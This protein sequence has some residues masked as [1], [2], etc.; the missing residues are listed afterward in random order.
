[1]KKIMFGLFI[2]IFI[3]LT[4]CDKPEITVPIEQPKDYS[5]S[6]E[7]LESFFTLESSVVETNR[8]YFIHVSFTPKFDY[9]D[10]I[11]TVTFGIYYEFT[12]Q[13]VLLNHYIE[14]T[15]TIHEDAV[16]SS[17][18]IQYFN[19]LSIVDVIVIEASGTFQSMETIALIQK[20]YIEPFD[21][22]HV[23]SKQIET[24]M[25]LKSQIDAINLAGQHMITKYSTITTESTQDGEHESFT[26]DY[27]EYLVRDPLYYHLKFNDHEFIH[28]I[29]DEQNVVYTWLGETFE[30]IKLLD[31]YVCKDDTTYPCEIP[32][33]SVISDTINLK[34]SKMTFEKDGHDF[35][36]RGLIKD[37]L[38]PYE[39]I[40]MVQSF[41]MMGLTQ[42]I[43]DQATF[44]LTLRFDQDLFQKTVVNIDI[45]SMDLHIKSTTEETYTF[46][47]ITPIDPF[48]HPSYQVLLPTSINAV[49]QDTDFLTEV[50]GGG[51]GQI[52]YYRSFLEKGVYRINAFD[53]MISFAL[54]DEAGHEI[55]NTIPNVYFSMPL[56]EVPHDGVYYVAIYRNDSSLPSYRF[57]FTKTDMMDFIYPEIDLN[58]PGEKSFIVENQDDLVRF[59]YTTTQK[60]VLTFTIISDQTT[61]FYSPYVND[62]INVTQAKTISVGVL[63]GTHTFYIGGMGYA[64]GTLS[65]EII[66]LPNIYSIS[67]TTL[68]ISENF[69]PSPIFYGGNLG[70]AYFILHVTETTTY[71]FEMTFTYATLYQK[72]G[73]NYM[74]LQTIYPN[75][76]VTL[77]PGTYYLSANSGFLSQG[78]IRYHKP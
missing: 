46:E 75:G 14:D 24:Y 16:S 63:P 60:E 9:I 64:A 31:L 68:E 47:S 53:S 54:F 17:Y 27:Y 69:F 65:V 51:R 44:E 43:V 77:E 2:L 21:R 58:I 74:T 30:N 12:Y 4:A 59:V 50:I 3:F 29:K 1:M 10:L 19:N 8:T 42:Y 26:T 66:V 11:G 62:Q 37:L 32:K 71:Q 52:H 33:D 73:S 20:T 67:Q 36:V 38:N 78:N 48:N 56:L 34:F 13:T 39:Y 28:T 45:P 55:F 40:S 41:L 18:P 7:T 23:T 35:I 22:N 72:I 15:L 25:D 61:K 49:Y 70:R 5:L 76:V 57:Q 6:A